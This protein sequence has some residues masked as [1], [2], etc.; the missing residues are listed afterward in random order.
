[1]VFAPNRRLLKAYLLKVSLD[2]LWSYQRD[3]AMLNYLQQWINELRWQRLQP[4][5]K[6]ASMLL[7]QLDGIQIYYRAKVPMGIEE[8]VDGNINTFLRRDRGYKNFRYLLLKAQRTAATRTEFVVFSEAAGVAAP[9]GLSRRARI[10][11]AID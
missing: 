1:M 2:R 5:Q 4:S 8:S 6:L 7:K 9:V 11:M 10:P 3:G